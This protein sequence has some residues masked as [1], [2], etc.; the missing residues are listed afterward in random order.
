MLTAKYMMNAA[1]RFKRFAKAAYYCTIIGLLSL[2]AGAM[3][4]TVTQ[5]QIFS[6]GRFALLD[7]VNVEQ[8]QLNI[9]GSFSQTSDIFF[10]DDPQRGYYDI[11]NGPPNT[12]YSVT[13]PTGDVVIPGEPG[14]S[15]IV[16][17]IAAGPTAKST[18]G[19]GNAT[20]WLYGDIRTR[21]NMDY[22]DQTVSGN[23][24]INVVFNN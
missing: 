8:I 12:T 21:G 1:S 24:E 17:N 6:F 13:V 11:T 15:M 10:I 20:F 3:A 9:D 22:T 19:D 2:P 23:I 18:D 14:R 7:F 4:Q 16:S 5:T